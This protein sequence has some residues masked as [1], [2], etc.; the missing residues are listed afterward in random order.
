M[1]GHPR[2]TRHF[3]QVP[4]N[5]SQTKRNNERKEF[6]KKKRTIQESVGSLKIIQKKYIS[7]RKKVTL[8]R[9]DFR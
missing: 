5:L 7:S 9:K 6:G 1:T 3:R 4:N 8:S 2:I